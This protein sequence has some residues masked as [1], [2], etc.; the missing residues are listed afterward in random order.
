MGTALKWFWSWWCSWPDVFPLC[1]LC[2]V[3]FT[4]VLGLTFF[5]PTSM[6]FFLHVFS[7][8][9][10]SHHLQQPQPFSGP[11]FSKHLTFISHTVC[12]VLCCVWSERRLQGCHQLMYIASNIAVFHC[13][14]NTPA[15]FWLSVLYCLF[16]MDWL[17]FTVKATWSS[18][19]S[20]AKHLRM[21]CH[22]QKILSTLSSCC[23]MIVIMLRVIGGTFPWSNEH[24]RWVSA[25]ELSWERSGDTAQRRGPAV[26]A[27]AA[28]T[29]GQTQDKPD[30]AVWTDGHAAWGGHCHDHHCRAA[31]GCLKLVR[32]IQAALRNLCF[33]LPT[34]TVFLQYTHTHC[35]LWN[36]RKLLLREG[37]QIMEYIR[38]LN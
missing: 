16:F 31:G 19:M 10:S 34:E 35:R 4:T 14:C 38:K 9:H 26:L 25:W 17:H 29:A 3:P 2:Y 27:R 18:E 7:Y 36:L 13:H 32:N 5:W 30:D 21:Q 12:H 22:L 23:F 20:G 33:R 11:L 28:T 24:V 37:A 1:T 15:T 6:P 8:S